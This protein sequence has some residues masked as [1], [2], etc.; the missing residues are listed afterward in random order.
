ME[1]THAILDALANEGAQGDR[2]SACA[3]K[4]L[5]ALANAPGEYRFEN[6]ICEEKLIALGVIDRS[7]PIV[8]IQHAA[9]M[10][11]LS[12]AFQSKKEL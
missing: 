12:Y 8:L 11:M 7:N 9:N 5:Y 4:E 1:D 2:A 6:R 3:L 10:A